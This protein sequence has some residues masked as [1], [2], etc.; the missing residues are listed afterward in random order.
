MAADA[1]QGAA[2]LRHPGR[3][4]VRAAGAEVG[5]ARDAEHVSGPPLGG[6]RLDERDPI[7]DGARSVEVGDARRERP[8]HIIRRDFRKAGQQHAARLVLLPDNPWA[9]SVGE[10]IERVSGLELGERH[11]LFHHEELFES[12]RE[13]AHRLRVERVRHRHLQHR[14][15]EIVRRPVVDAEIEQR[16][17]DVVES[18]AG[19]D[20]SVARTPARDHHPVQPVGPRIRHR[21][22]EL[23]VPV[24]GFHLVPEVGNSEV[25]PVRGHLELAG[26]HDL[27]VERI[28]RER[29][30]RIHRIGHRLVAHPRPREPRERDAVQAVAQHLV[31]VGGIEKG[32]HELD[33]GE[34][35]GGRRVGRGEGVIVADHD[36]HSAV[37]GAA[38][39]VAVADRVH[40]P[41]EARTLAVPHGEDSIVPAVAELRR[42]LAAPDR[43]RG[44]ILV[45]GRLEMDVGTGEKAI[46]G[47]QLLVD[48]VHRGAAVAGDVAGSVEARRAVAD[49]LH[50][51]ESHERLAARDVNPSFPALVLVVQ[52]N[53]R[54]LHDH[55]P[56]TANGQLR[57]AHGVRRAPPL[58]PVRPSS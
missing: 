34:L 7:V 49:A 20:D 2:S 57:A 9:P 27:G 11:L 55:P 53:R 30:A 22:V 29:R 17:A 48:V 25:E 52:R 18:L 16:L 43:G 15:P 12:V 4:V 54:E 36:Q 33:E 26:E 39:H 50:H 45:D 32:H 35:V 38:R 13:V 31:H 28:G 6:L 47:P 10:R 42:L 21:R 23:V 41:I 24:P 51:R 37:A 8:G 3:G 46:R 40:A 1:S 19:G 14:D 5:G 56:V 44:Q 58:L